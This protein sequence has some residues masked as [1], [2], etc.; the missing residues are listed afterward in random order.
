MPP[1]EPE[2]RGGAGD[3]LFGKEEAEVYAHIWQQV[4]S[5]EFARVA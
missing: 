2:R 4:I 5:G 3:P 1:D